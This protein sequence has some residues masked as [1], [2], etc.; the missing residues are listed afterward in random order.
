MRAKEPDQARVQQ[1]VESYLKF[2][3]EDQ[4]LP[5]VTKSMLAALKSWAG[6]FYRCPVFV[7]GI[8][9]PPTR[10]SLRLGNRYYPHMKLAI[11]IS[12]D[13]QQWLFKADTHDRHCCPPSNSPEF[14]AFNELMQK[15]QRM[16]EAIETAWAEQGI[17]T[18]KTFLREDLARRQAA[19]GT[20]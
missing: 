6:E 3:Y 12:P 9:N 19:A 4:P 2:A 18:L 17:P 14:A 20:H 13:D 8:D 5:T 1:A 10:Y 7:R 11:E 15:N 16:A